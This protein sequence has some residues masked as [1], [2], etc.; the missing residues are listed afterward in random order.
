[1][2]ARG[3]IEGLQFRHTP[4]DIDDETAWAW[5]DISPAEFIVH[6]ANMYLYRSGGVTPKGDP[7]W[8]SVNA[9][10]REDKTLSVR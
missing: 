1:M 8:S 4:A 9:P 7:L 6:A 10:S 2:D 3:G 5:Q